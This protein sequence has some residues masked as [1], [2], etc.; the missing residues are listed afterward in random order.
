MNVIDS[1]SSARDAGGKPGATF[2][3]PALEH[4]PT[5][6]THLVEKKSLQI[7]MFEHSLIDQIERYRLGRT[8]RQ[9]TEPKQEL[10][11]LATE[12]LILRRDSNVL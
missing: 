11:R 8:M 9:A 4:F 6:W 5:L 10:L 12:V 7:S 2:P 1:K 3:H